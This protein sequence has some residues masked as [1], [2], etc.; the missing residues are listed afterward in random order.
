[1]NILSNGI[2]LIWQY[3]QNLWRSEIVEKS[4]AVDIF[5]QSNPHPIFNCIPN[6]RLQQLVFNR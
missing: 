2:L 5:L 4:P 1:M 3:Y 6:Y